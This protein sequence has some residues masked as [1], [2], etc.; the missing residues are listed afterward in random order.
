MIKINKIKKIIKKLKKFTIIYKY[1]R[2]NNILRRSSLSFYIN[3]SNSNYKSN[4]LEGN[5]PRKKNFFE[6]Y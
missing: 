4:K 3:N 5:Y 2:Y 1:I 6:F